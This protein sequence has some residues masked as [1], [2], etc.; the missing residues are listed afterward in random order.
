ML[1][2]VGWRQ[3]TGEH[4]EDW[5]AW[6]TAQIGDVRRQR[7]GLDPKEQWQIEKTV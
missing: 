7:I 1:W 6:V 5:R 3:L 2:N 4:D